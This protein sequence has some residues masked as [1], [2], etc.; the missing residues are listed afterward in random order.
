M[1]AQPETT[2]ALIERNDR[3]ITLTFNRDDVRNE[4]T[5][6]QLVNDICRTV[7]WSTPRGMSPR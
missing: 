6:T 7:E 2:D 5:G 3:V 4:L 1:T